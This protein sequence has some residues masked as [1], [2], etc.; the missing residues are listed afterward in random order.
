[1]GQGEGT[2]PVLSLAQAEASLSDRAAMKGSGS[3]SLVDLLQSLGLCKEVLRKT[4]SLA[5]EVLN[6]SEGFQRN[7]LWP[8]LLPE[9]GVE[10]RIP[11]KE[12]DVVMGKR[13]VCLSDMLIPGVFER[14][15]G[16][17]V[18]RYG[19]SCRQCY[20][21]G[22]VSREGLEVLVEEGETFVDIVVAADSEA[23]LHRAL[24]ALRNMFRLLMQ[25]IP[26]MKVIEH[27]ISPT[28]LRAGVPKMERRTLLRSSLPEHTDVVVMGDATEKIS[29]LLLPSEIPA[30]ESPPGSSSGNNPFGPEA[31]KTSLPAPPAS[32]NPFAV[33]PRRLDPPPVLAR[34]SINPFFNVGNCSNS[35]VSSN[36]SIKA[37]SCIESMPNLALSPEASPSVASPSVASPSAFEASP[38]SRPQRSSSSLA[39]L[40]LRALLE[41][42]R[43][44]ASYGFTTPRYEV[45]LLAPG[46]LALTELKVMDERLPESLR[47]ERA[48]IYAAVHQVLDKSCIAAFNAMGSDDVFPI[49]GAVVASVSTKSWPSMHLAAPLS[50][51]EAA[52]L[53]DEGAYPLF[54]QL[55]QAPSG[56]GSAP[57]SPPDLKPLQVHLVQ[58]LVMTN[59]ELEHTNE[60]WIYS[61]NLGQGGQWLLA[62]VA[63]SSKLPELGDGM[64]LDMTEYTLVGL[65]S[66]SEE[67]ALQ[68]VKE[69]D[70][71]EMLLSLH[72]FNTDLNFA[73]RTAASYV[74]SLHR[75]LVVSMTW[76]SDPPAE[77]R[78]WLISQ[79]MS[80]YERMYTYAEHNMHASIMPLVES[81]KVLHAAA[82]SSNKVMEWKA[83]SMGCY[84]LL[85]FIDRLTWAGADI[86]GIFP[87]VILDA[88]DCPSWFF[89]SVVG[90]ACG[91]GVEICHY[92][93]PGDAATEASRVRR[94]SPK[95]YPGNG[96]VLGCNNLQTVKCENMKSNPVNHDYG[97]CDG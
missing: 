53:L 63:Y 92:Y 15:Q 18:G 60:V 4:D 61:S 9:D 82:A 58:V 12:G 6:A 45:C 28:S 3:F 49:K 31:P 10:D 8:A 66:L 67:Q 14:F 35:S 41:P 19:D 72:G 36:S 30:D 17:L 62:T 75:P 42:S 70:S 29:E 78:G 26:A 43:S 80:S 48:N 69:H 77:G 81:I 51:Q 37:D 32:S 24:E 97:R 16:E 25:E 57:N 23:V 84:L 27:L 22:R 96:A 11:F 86:P 38:S 79:V 64:I 52:E 1:M 34:K 46:A 88:P 21:L 2:G 20:G 39:S 5:H 90:A 68:I 76:P 47:E 89:R 95:P 71:E 93:N 33:S 13:M 44:G 59:R 87:K 85:N 55:I 40:D 65:C 50:Y 54:V 56:L 94:A 7:F 83:H 74:R 91:K 73:V